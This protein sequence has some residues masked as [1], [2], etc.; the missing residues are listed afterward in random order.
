MAPHLT[1]AR[2]TGDAPVE[3]NVYGD[4]SINL[5]D[6]LGWRSSGCGGWWPRRTPEDSPEDGAERAAAFVSLLDGGLA[7]HSAMPGHSSSSTRMEIGAAI[8]AAL[9][10]VPAHFASD[11]A[12][13][14]AVARRLLQAHAQGTEFPSRWSP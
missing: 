1:V 12:A 6:R 5:L 13:Y 8:I 3:A 14:V 10:P 9:A 7:L 4:G 11:R 2:V